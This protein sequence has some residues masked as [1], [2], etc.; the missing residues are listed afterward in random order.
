MFVI[1]LGVALVPL[2]VLGDPPVY[3]AKEIR[4]QVVDSQTG[5]GLEDVVVLAEWKPYHIGIGHGS[6]GAPM[7]SV[8]VVTDVNGRYV[9]PAW[10]PRLRP[11]LSYLNG[12]D[13]KIRY[14]KGGFYPQ[15]Q[16]NNPTSYEG[17][18][19]SLVR[20]SDWDGK[21][22]KLVP[23]NGTDWEE[24]TWK[25]SSSWYFGFD[26]LRDCPRMVLAL[27]AEG[28]RVERLAPKDRI[29]WSGISVENFAE[30]DRAFFKRLKK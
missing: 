16:S 21:V 10:G 30:E 26:C 29:E 28:K 6:T 15:A 12:L 3:S 18:D 19:R 11:P 24:Y 9:I 13:P 4:G 2:Y 5:K 14:F 25:I 8:E 17:R 1:G 20:K 7:K 23:F 22:I 27:E